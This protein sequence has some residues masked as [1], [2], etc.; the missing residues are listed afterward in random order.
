MARETI[1]LT[2]K[3]IGS[4]ID[5]KAAIPAIEHAMGEFERGNDFLPPKAIYPF[6]FPAPAGAWRPASPA[7][8]RPP[9][10]FP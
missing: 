10:C 4:R 3:D 1:I 5:I 2:R 8:P 6:R 9:T 7:I